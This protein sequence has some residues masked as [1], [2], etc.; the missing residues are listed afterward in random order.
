L[1]ANCSPAIKS[2]ATENTS[3]VN[4]YTRKPIFILNGRINGL[5]YGTLFP[6]VPAIFLDDAD[7]SRLWSGPNRVLYLDWRR[8]EAERPFE[9]SVG[10]PAG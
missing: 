7:F 4:F 9:N 10:I 3:S 1:N 5:W 8:M 6:D 2:S